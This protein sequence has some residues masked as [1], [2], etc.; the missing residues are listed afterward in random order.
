MLREI[1]Q[2]GGSPSNLAQVGI[3]SGHLSDPPVVTVAIN[4]EVLCFCASWWARA[5]RP[6]RRSGMP[7]SP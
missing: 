2:G 1:T 4:G 6:T 5:R 3:L 7:L